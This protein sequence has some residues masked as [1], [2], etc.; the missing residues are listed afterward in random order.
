MREETRCHHM[1]YSFRLTARVLLYASSHREVSTY[2]SLCYTSHGALAAMRNRSM[3]P[4]HEG[5]IRHLPRHAN[6][7]LQYVTKIK[8]LPAHNGVFVSKYLKLLIQSEIPSWHYATLSTYIHLYPLPTLSFI[9]ILF[10]H[11][12]LHW[13]LYFYIKS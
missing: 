7:H 12:I 11:T 6:I 9:H 4:P 3:G 2:H 1:G 13:I 10:C 8:L 5:S